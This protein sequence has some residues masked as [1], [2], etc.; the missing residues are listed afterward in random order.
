MLALRGFRVL[1]TNA[2]QSEDR[3]RTLPLQEAPPALAPPKRRPPRIVPG[4]PA[5]VDAVA[6]RKGGAK[7]ACAEAPSGLAVHEVAVIAAALA[8]LDARLRQPLC[9]DR[10]VDPGKDC[11]RLHLANRE[12]EAGL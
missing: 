6:G 1:R 10:F 7:D 2:G 8:I 5:G 4:L 11:L 3:V 12:A 9:A